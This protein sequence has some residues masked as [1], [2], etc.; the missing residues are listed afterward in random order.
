[1]QRLSVGRGASSRVMWVTTARVGVEL[2][3]FIYK[4]L[5]IDKVKKMG[6]GG[7]NVVG[8]RFDD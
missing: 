3:V 4:L 2:N 7:N 6:F 5:Y 1:M 8:G